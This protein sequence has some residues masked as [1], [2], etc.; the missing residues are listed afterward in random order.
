MDK[1]KKFIISRVV[2]EREN[3]YTIRELEPEGVY[4][5]INQDDILDQSVSDYSEVLNVNAFIRAYAVLSVQSR[6]FPFRIQE[7]VNDSV[8]ICLVR[9]CEYCNFK[10][11]F[12]CLTQAF[13]GIGSNID[14]SFGSI[15]IRENDV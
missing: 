6:V 8:R 7:L 10:A 13:F 5:V 2:V 1:L 14:A 12:C 11:K 9:C 15:P 3:R 4:C